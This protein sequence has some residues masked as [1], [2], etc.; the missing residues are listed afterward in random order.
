MRKIALEFK[1]RETRLSRPD[2]DTIVGNAIRNS[3]VKVDDPSSGCVII[4]CHSVA[5]TA[6]KAAKEWGQKGIEVIID[7]CLTSY[8]AQYKGK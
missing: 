3:I 5:S 1:Y 2:V 8:D 4:K 6:Y 7:P